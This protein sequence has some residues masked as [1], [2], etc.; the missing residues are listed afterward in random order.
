M[1]FDTY[2]L[3]IK[4]DPKDSYAYNQRGILLMRIQESEYSIRDFS[5]ALS[6]ERNDSLKA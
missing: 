1:L 2:S 5:T 6:Y 3:A 4:T